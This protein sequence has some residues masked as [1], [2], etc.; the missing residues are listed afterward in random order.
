[1]KIMAIDYGEKYIGIAVNEPLF[2]TVHG[3]DTLVRKTLASDMAYL[4]QLMRREE[5]DLLVVGL[6]LNEAG[7]ETVTSEHVRRFVKQLKKKMQYSAH[8]YSVVPIE[9]FDERYTTQD[10]HE[11][12]EADWIPKRER[13][14]YL[15]KLSA[16][17]L[18]EAYLD[19]HRA[20]FSDRAAGN[21]ILKTERGRCEE[22]R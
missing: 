20:D 6:P 18:L 19:A 5:V 9:F 1:M 17:L 12:L 14:R 21:C 2:M 10:A 3:R 4:L 16:I 13:K 22:R 7:E 8:G 15:D 11:I